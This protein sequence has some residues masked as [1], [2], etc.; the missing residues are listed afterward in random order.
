VEGLT[1]VAVAISFR[2][3][4]IQPLQDRAH[5]TLKYCRQSDPTRVL[6]RKVSG[7]R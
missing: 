6:Q 1:G 4:L 3:R 2:R 7:R 5:P